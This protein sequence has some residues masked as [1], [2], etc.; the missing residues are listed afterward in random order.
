M[1]PAPPPDLPATVTAPSPRPRRA[2]LVVAAAAAGVLVCAALL[3]LAVGLGWLSVVGGISL[4]TLA[5][6]VAAFAV[7]VL[8]IVRPIRALVA[9]TERL[10]AGDLSQRVAREGGGEIGQLGRAFNTMASSLEQN[11]HDLEVQNVEL[12]RLAHVLRAVLDSTVDGILLTDV[13]GNVQ[14]AN[15][16]MLR[17]AAELG[18]DQ[19]GS[20][21]DRLLSIAPK[22]ADGERFRATMERLRARPDEPSL[23]EFELVDPRRTFQGFTAP[24]RGD[25]GGF[26]GRIWTLREMTQERELERL[27]DDFVASVSHE[28]RTPLTAI[29]GFLELL[30]AGTPG[31]LTAEQ[32]RYVTIAHRSAERL[33]RLVGDL[34]F[35]AYLDAS[36]LALRLGDVDLGAVVAEGVDAVSASAGAREIDL[37]HEPQTMPRVR[38]DR[39]RLAQLVESLLENALK[40]TPSGG[41]VTARTFAEPGLVV[42]EVEDT[43]AGIST[44][45]QQRLFAR[46]VRAP[47]ASAQA[48]PG[49]GLGLV[50]AKSIVDAHGGRLTVASEPGSGT[51]F[52]VELPLT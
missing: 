27:K 22:V 2:V 49:L 28:L 52:R 36:G 33:Q 26:V 16:P 10:A 31:P 7:Y 19:H 1:P 43:G 46:F 47:V 32:A 40:F 35:V 29:L 11:R 34:L 39:E 15:R 25:G 8:E 30:R 9:A 12:V 42:L 51:C 6:S 14:L 23:D 21:T 18:F 24:V 37:R 20:A 50:I 4:A 13:D 17:Y 44:D 48:I 5:L 3:V 41:S 45:D 38:G